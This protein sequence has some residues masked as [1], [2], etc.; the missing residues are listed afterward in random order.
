MVEAEEVGSAKVEEVESAGIMKV[1]RPFGKQTEILEEPSEEGG[2]FMWN[3][4]GKSGLL[5]SIIVVRTTTAKRSVG[6]R[7]AIQLPQ[8]RKSS[9]TPLTLNS[10]TTEAC[11]S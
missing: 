6:K 2:V 11:S 5:L 8:V 1:T 7:E 4:V 10:K 3:R 9:I